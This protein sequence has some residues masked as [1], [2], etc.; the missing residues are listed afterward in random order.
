MTNAHPTG[1][2]PPSSTGRRA[3][4]LNARRLV[5]RLPRGRLEGPGAYGDDHT[6]GLGWPESLAL[7]RAMRVSIEGRRVGCE[8]WL[9]PG[10][11]RRGNYLGGGRAA[12]PRLLGEAL[13]RVRAASVNDWDW[14]LLAGRPFLNRVNGAGGLR[15]PRQPIPGCDIAAVVVEV[16]TKV[17]GVAVGDEVL[18]VLSGCGFGA[19][20]EFACPPT[21]VLRRK[22]AGLSGSRR[23]PCRKPDRWPCWRCAPGD[24]CSRSRPSW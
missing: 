20:A 4:R 21:Q 24:R 5:R 23:R 3:P 10:M 8:R 1:A 7:S 12:C 17:V 2:W 19:F 22:P 6:G 16:G 11:A 14:Q 15:G 9:S 18:A 13:V